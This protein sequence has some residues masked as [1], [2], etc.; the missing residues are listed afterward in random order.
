VTFS[1]KGK[2]VWVAGHRGMAGSAIVRRLASEDCEILTARRDEVDLRRQER[3]EKW[4]AERRPQAVFLAAATVGG[5]LANDTRPA[6]FIYDNLAIEINVIHAAR[7]SGVEKLLFLSSSCVYPRL[8]PQPM[9]EDA[10]LTG[11]LEP[12][13]QW[14]A[15]AKIAGMMLCRAYRRQYGC[16]FI[17]AMPTNLYGPGDNY[18]P[19][20]S[21]VAAALQV[22]VHRAKTEGARVMQVWGTGKPTREFLYVDDLADALVF[23][24]KNYTGEQHVNVGTGIETTIAD[25]AQLIARAAAWEGRFEYDRA[26]PDG[27]PRK[28]MDVS[29]LRALGWTARTPLDEGFRKAYDWY[30]KNAAARVPQT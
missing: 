27:M 11:P 2:K 16:D 6:E 28:V 30:V 14:Y 20:S 1:L 10:L 5:I 18:D 8:A 12:T 21:H 4:M 13:N 19:A 7:A 9:T 26:K 29:R 25:L 24:M 17:S 3:V 15:A 23:L 22:K